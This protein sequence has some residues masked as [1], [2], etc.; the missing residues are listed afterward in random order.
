MRSAR[1]ETSER[2]SAMRSKPGW[3]DRI[4]LRC[5]FSRRFDGLWI[6]VF[7]GDNPEAALSRVEEAL[8]LIKTHDRRRYNR[9]MRDLERVWVRLLFGCWGCYNSSLRGCEL[10]RRFVTD[11]RTTP[12]LIATVIVHEATHA[13][14][15]AHGVGSEETMRARVEAVCIRRELAFTSRL[16]NAKEVREWSKGKL[17]WYAVSEYL[18]D[19]AQEQCFREDLIE[20]WQKA[21]LPGRLVPVMLAPRRTMLAVRRTIKAVFH[22]AVMCLTL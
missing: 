9:L 18:T 16:P 4:Y 6:G 22:G 11:A 2:H 19:A 12:E 17:E 3:M 7:W 8:E 14:L 5:S 15:H 10:D 20:E 1:G 13:R 21:G